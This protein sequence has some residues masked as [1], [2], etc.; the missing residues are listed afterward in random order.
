MRC[1]SRVAGG[2][3]AGRTTHPQAAGFLGDEN[4][5]D[6][7][8]Q[9]R[10]DVHDKRARSIVNGDVAGRVHP[11]TIVSLRSPRRVPSLHASAWAGGGLRAVSKGRL[12]HGGVKRAGGLAQDGL[13]NSEGGRVVWERSPES[14]AVRPEWNNAKREWSGLATARPDGAEDVDGA[15]RQSCSPGWA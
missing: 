9:H 14:A 15:K 1:C 4:A 10:D 13:T 11:H 6:V 12:S 7:V 8:R 2:E 3:Q 5:E